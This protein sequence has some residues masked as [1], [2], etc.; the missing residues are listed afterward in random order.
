MLSHTLESGAISE[1]IHK[2]RC[3][4]SSKDLKN[5]EIFLAR[6]PS[7]KATIMQAVPML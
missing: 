3:A 6:S 4:I 1:Q 7:P 2:K 5:I